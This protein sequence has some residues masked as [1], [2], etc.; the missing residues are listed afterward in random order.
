MRAAS[1]RT[2]ERLEMADEVTLQVTLIGGQIPVQGQ[3][4]PLVKP[5]H[6]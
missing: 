5:V 2:L 6:G 4:E 1:S 3:V